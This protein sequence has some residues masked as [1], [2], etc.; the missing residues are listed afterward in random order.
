MPY[1][2]DVAPVTHAE[3][4]GSRSLA[5]ATTTCFTYVSKLF[6]SAF[7]RLLH[8]LPR[9]ILPFF[10]YHQTPSLRFSALLSSRLVFFFSIR[11]LPLTEPF[12]GRFGTFPRRLHGEQVPCIAHNEFFHLSCFGASTTACSNTCLSHFLVLHFRRGH[13]ACLGKDIEYT[14]T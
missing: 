9:S 12:C 6:V 5:A 10:R 2:T 7:Q 1:R 13:G 4:A 8:P 14:R 3:R 11:I